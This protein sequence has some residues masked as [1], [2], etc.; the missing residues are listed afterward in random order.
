MPAIIFDF[1]GVLINSEGLWA[2]AERQFFRRLFPKWSP[3]D[4]EK[5]MGLNLEDTYALL[6]ADYGLPLTEKEFSAEFESIAQVIYG[7]KAKPFPGVVRLVKE[8]DGLRIP[9]GIASSSRLSW[10]MTALERLALAEHFTTVVSSEEVP[11]A[12][13]PKPDVYLLAARHL[14]LEPS[15]CIAIEDSRNGI[16]AAKNAGMR[17]IA[18]RSSSSEKQ[19]IARADAVIDSLQLHA[20]DLLKLA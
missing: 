6:R 3:A 8:L 7:S 12:G 13:K 5:L 20:E 19:D 10:I 15:A 17:C 4:Q 14:D 1:D 2:K 16:L 9:I 11:G 18:F